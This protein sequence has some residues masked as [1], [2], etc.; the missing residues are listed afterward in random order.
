MNHRH[1]DF[2]S[3]AL[4]TELPG[5]IANPVWMGSNEERDSSL[6][7][8]TAHKASVQP[9]FNEKRWLKQAPPKWHRRHQPHAIHTGSTPLLTI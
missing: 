9:E 4:P 7:D 3:A 2:Q 6:E 5:Q 1:A 8:I